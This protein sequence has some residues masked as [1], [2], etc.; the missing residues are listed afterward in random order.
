MLENYFFKGFVVLGRN[1]NNL[2]IISNEEKQT[3][4]AMGMHDFDYVITCTT[5]I[6]Y[7]SN[8]LK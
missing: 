6:P 3:I 7:I 5:A 4:H 2:N 1:S 8:T